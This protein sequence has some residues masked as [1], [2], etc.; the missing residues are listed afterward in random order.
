MDYASTVGR[1]AGETGMKQLV[2]R[3]VWRRGLRQGDA[4]RPSAR[5]ERDLLALLAVR[6][7]WSRAARQ[8]AMLGGYGR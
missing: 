8:G 4:T 2:V 1:R 7:A 3:D 6:K 5:R